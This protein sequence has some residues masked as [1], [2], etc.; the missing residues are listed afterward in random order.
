MLAPERGN[1]QLAEHRQYM[2]V[3][4]LAISPGRVRL[5][6]HRHML[7]EISF[8]ELGH[9]RTGIC[10]RLGRRYRFLA[11][12]DAGDDERRPSARPVG[13]DHPVP[14]E[15]NPLRSAR[16]PALDQVDLGAGRIYAHSEALEFPVPDDDVLVLDGQAVDGTLRQ[17]RVP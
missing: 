13:G 2:R 16:S 5:A 15:G 12:L 17:R 11:R 1:R 10:E 14:A 8:G 9:R 4:H 7:R 6:A 3:D